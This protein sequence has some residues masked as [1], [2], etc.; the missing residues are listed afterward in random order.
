MGSPIFELFLKDTYAFV[1][2]VEENHSCSD[3]AASLNDII[4][5]DVA[6]VHQHKDQNLFKS[7]RKP[8]SLDSFF[9]ST[10]TITP[11]M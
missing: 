8:I 1:G 6:Y 7:P 10:A 2:Q 5:D 4:V 11:V 3:N 9:S